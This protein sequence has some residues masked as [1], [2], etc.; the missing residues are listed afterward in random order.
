MY[1]LYVSPENG[2]RSGFKNVGFVQNTVMADKSQKPN[3][4]NLF[5]ISI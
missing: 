5:M 4:T 1:L 2:M 3:N